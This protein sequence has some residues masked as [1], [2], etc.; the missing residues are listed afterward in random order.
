VADH[1]CSVRH[2]S[3]DHGNL[4]RSKLNARSIEVKPDPTSNDEG[5]SFLR[6]RLPRKDRPACVAVL[7][8][9]LLIAM[10]D[11]AINARTHRFCWSV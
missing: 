5:D 11:P 1:L 4:T 7:H 9:R 8:H 2:A 6:T 3:R 10:D